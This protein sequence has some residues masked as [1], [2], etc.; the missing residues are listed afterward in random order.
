[1]GTDGHVRGGGCVH[2]ME[3]RP[4]IVY[5]MSPMRGEAGYGGETSYW[6]ICSFS[7]ELRLYEY[8]CPAVGRTL[9]ST[10]SNARKNTRGSRR[11]RDDART[12]LRAR[13]AESFYLCPWG[14]RH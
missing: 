7:F 11:G 5:Y 4:V 2:G 8:A 1:M 9:Y 12:E 13:G 14:W 10:R 6:V 3:T